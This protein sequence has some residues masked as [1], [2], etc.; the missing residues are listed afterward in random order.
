MS[1]PVS[2]SRRSMMALTTGAAAS[3]AL[4]LPAFATTK[5]SAKKLVERVVADINTIIDSGKSEEA[6][7]VDFEQVFADYADVNTIARYALGVEA[8]SASDAQLKAFTAAFRKYM[9]GKYG[10][11]FREFIGGRVEVRDARAVKSFFEVTA[12]A[13]LQGMAPFELTFLVTDRSG[14][15]KFFNMFIEGLNMLLSER[16]EIGAM[17]DN[18]RGDL[19]LTIQDLQKLK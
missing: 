8:R 6:M 17:L 15:E 16:T 9:S 4:P 3:V 12:M 7:L 1:N 18:R 11:R 19:D 5:R 10:R 14:E 13:H 2:L